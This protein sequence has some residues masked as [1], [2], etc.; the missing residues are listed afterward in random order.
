MPKDKNETIER[1]YKRMM[2]ELSLAESL[3]GD[4]LAEIK[5]RMD[6]ELEKELEEDEQES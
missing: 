4:R 5:K 1:Y 6:E 2:F 3:F